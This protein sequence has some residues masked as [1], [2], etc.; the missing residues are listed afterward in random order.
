MQ[1]QLKCKRCGH[2]WYRRVPHKPLKCPNCQARD[3]EKPGRRT[4]IPL[5]Q[6]P[7]LAA[8]RES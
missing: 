4:I 8:Q 7:E 3:W 1:A 5:E 6:Q 2:E